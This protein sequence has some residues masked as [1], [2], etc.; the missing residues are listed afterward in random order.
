MSVASS[1]F[2]NK[3][4]KF[5]EEFPSST[6]VSGDYPLLPQRKRVHKSR[7]KGG[8]QPV[9]RENLEEPDLKLKQL[10]PFSGVLAADFLP[11]SAESAGKS[12]VIEKTLSRCLHFPSS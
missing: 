3:Q 5:A 1:I 12:M 7:T 6:P 4:L 2:F 11:F 10:F 8:T 9:V